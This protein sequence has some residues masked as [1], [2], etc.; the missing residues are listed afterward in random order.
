M[1]IIETFRSSSFPTIQ[2]QMATVRQSE[3]KTMRTLR[4][5]DSKASLK[6][7][8]DSIRWDDIYTETLTPKNELRRFISIYMVHPDHPLKIFFDMFVMVCIVFI[9]IIL[10]VEIAFDLETNA[11]LEISLNVIFG[12]DLLLGFNTGY[13]Y[14]VR[15][16]CFSCFKNLSV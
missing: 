5:L 13:A 7:R 1:T 4:A 10:P 6:T 8:C 11:F 15:F 2:I 14:Q 16:S 3:S 12:I 9:A